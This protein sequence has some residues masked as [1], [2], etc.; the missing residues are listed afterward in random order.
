ML[1]NA[2]RSQPAYHLSLARFA[3]DLRDFGVLHSVNSYLRSVC[4]AD[5]EH[6]IDFLLSLLSQGNVHRATVR[7]SAFL[8]VPYTDLHLS[9]FG[10][11]NVLGSNSF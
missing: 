1:F 4:N 2:V 9:S 3:E 6:T 10:I 5:M 8:I 7:Q 11:S